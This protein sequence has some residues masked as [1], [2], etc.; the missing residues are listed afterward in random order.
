MQIE[1]RVRDAAEETGIVCCAVQ[2]PDGQIVVVVMNTND[3]EQAVCVEAGDWQYGLTMEEHSI[4]TIL[5]S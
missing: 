4:A 3:E 5:V 1:S 2:N